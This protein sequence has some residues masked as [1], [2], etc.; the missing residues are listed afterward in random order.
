MKIKKTFS[1]AVFIYLTGLLPIFKST[2][3]QEQFT[4]SDNS[5]P[6]IRMT[7]Y[8]GVQIPL[9]PDEFTNNFK[10]GKNFGGELEFPFEEEIYSV[11]ISYSQNSFDFDE[12]GAKEFFTSLL[13]LRSVSKV[14]GPSGSMWVVTAGMILRSEDDFLLLRA[15]LGYF[16]FSRGKVIVWG[17]DYASRDSVL[18]TELVSK[19][20]FYASISVGINFKI[21]KTIAV[22]LLVDCAIAASSKDEPTGWLIS[23]GGGPYEIERKNSWL[24]SF[25]TGI[26]ISL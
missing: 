14:E 1:I 20:G 12:V 10:T 8:G 9:G 5:F 22:P 3:A 25:R 2:W 11:C 13:G 21:S 19:D 16:N 6:H 24:L 15:D 4:I 7:V 23:Y 26:R 17:I 18:N